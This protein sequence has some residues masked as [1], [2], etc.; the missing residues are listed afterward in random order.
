MLCGSLK[1][2]TGSIFFNVYNSSCHSKNLTKDMKEW[3]L[4][5]YLWCILFA[6]SIDSVIVRE[7]LF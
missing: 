7:C 4:W 5:K 2:G 3:I 6:L 1:A